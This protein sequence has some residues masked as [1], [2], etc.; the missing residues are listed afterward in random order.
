MGIEGAADSRALCH[1]QN[2]RVER[3]KRHGLMDVV[4]IAI[5]AVIS[6]ADGWDDIELLAM[7]AARGSR[8]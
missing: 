2:P 7:L 3:T 1:L 8:S 5:L 4:V 6:G